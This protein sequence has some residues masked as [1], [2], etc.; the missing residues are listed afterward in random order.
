MFDVTI[1]LSFVG[2]LFPPWAMEWPAKRLLGEAF[3]ELQLKPYNLVA[4]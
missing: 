2:G 4:F 3:L 1:A